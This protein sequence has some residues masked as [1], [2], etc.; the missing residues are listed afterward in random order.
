M[1]ICTYITSMYVTMTKERGY[2]FDREKG[3]VYGRFCRKKEK[4]E[5]I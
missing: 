4:V 5:I 1:Y 3:G 2:E